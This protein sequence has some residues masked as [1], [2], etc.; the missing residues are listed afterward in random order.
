[1][2]NVVLAIRDFGDIEMIKLFNS[3]DE[4]HG[5]YDRIEFFTISEATAAKIASGDYFA[6]RYGKTI[7]AYCN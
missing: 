2:K 4:I 3:Y 5:L 1:M 6:K 7:R